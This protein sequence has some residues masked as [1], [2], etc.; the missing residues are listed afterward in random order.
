M[1]GQPPQNM[2]QRVIYIPADDTNYSDAMTSFTTDL[3][4]MNNYMDSPCQLVRMDGS[5]VQY[6]RIE[7]NLSAT[8]DTAI[9]QLLP[10]LASAFAQPAI[11][12]YI[13]AVQQAQEDGTQ[14]PPHRPG[15][16]H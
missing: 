12:S 11:R 8:Q 13:V 5:T 10:Q 2:I 4:N 3:Q 15:G 1:P 9:Q 14:G 6:R 16:P 7:I